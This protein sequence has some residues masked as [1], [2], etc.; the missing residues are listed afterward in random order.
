MLVKGDKKKILVVDDEP[1][2]RQLVSR[3]LSKDYIVIE[4]A[5]GQEALDL[6]QSKKP[7]VI[8]MD[9]MMPRMDGLTACH[10]LKMGKN[11]RDIPVVMLTAIDTEGNRKLAKE[12]WGAD[13]YLTK[14][15]ESRT[16][17]DTI[18]HFLNADV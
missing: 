7:A 13:E 9:M 15:F 3:M 4:A 6:A 16:L 10:V 11:T 8:L 2:V 17:F 14:P 18:G 1:G 12:V 5:N